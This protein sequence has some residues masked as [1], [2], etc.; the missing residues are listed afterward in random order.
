M[1]VLRT[2]HQQGKDAFVS[3]VELLRIPGHK[4]LE[5]VPALA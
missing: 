3:L 5:I 4:I 2:F 1:S